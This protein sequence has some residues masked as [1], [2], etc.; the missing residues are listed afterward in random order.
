MNNARPNT[1]TVAACRPPRASA[2]EIKSL[3]N[4]AR[5]WRT[6]LSQVL[7]EIYFLPVGD[8]IEVEYLLRRFK[9]ACFRRRYPS[10]SLFGA[11]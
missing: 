8:A 2:A 9:G 10:L 11:E 6:E 3:G 5:R 4:I 7:T 1:A